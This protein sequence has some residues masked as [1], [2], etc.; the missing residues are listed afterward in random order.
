M[1]T[2]GANIRIILLIQKECYF[3]LMFCLS[4][5]SYMPIY[6]HILLF[7]DG[8]ISF[9]GRFSLVYIQG[10]SMFTRYAYFVFPKRG[11]F[12]LQRY[13]FCTQTE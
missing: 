12:F 13:V 2:D 9:F 5:C 7:E 11:L 10:S 1:P 4:N 3:F 6:M 8:R